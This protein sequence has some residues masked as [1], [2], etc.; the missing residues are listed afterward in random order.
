MRITYRAFQNNGDMQADA[1][2]LRPA[3]VREAGPPASQQDADMLV[4]RPGLVE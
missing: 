4:R 2:F 3:M 1:T